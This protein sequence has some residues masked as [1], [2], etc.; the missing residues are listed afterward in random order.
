VSGVTDANWTFTGAYATNTTFAT[1]GRLLGGSAILPSPYAA[2]TTFSFVI[3][4]WSSTIAGED[5]VGVQGF[6]HNFELDPNAS[7]S[8]GQFFGTSS[9][10]TL[11]V[12]GVPGLP[13]SPLFGTTPGDTIQGFVLDQ[14][15]IP[16]PS[17]FAIIGL[18]SAALMVFRRR[19]KVGSGP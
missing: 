18:G 15:P 19:F 11:A 17:I 6:M 9:V 14:V 10:A 4:G 7:G 5:W 13:D 16:E 3:R 1:G 2:G 12:G 8:V